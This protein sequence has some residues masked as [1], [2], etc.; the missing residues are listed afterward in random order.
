MILYF[1]QVFRVEMFDLVEV[2]EEQH[3][4][5]FA[6]DCYVIL[7]AYRFC[8]F[9][10]LNWDKGSHPERKVQF[11]FNIVQTG[12]GVIPMLKKYVVNFV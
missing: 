4:V 5:F 8:H 2:P 10:I 3:G 6:G 7:Y 12:G 1:P 9:E 11:F